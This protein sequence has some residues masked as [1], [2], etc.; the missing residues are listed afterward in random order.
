MRL[1]LTYLLP[2]HWTAVF[3]LSAAASAGE[4]GLT[5]SMLTFGLWLG[6]SGAASLILPV[7]LGL[8]ATLFFW[9][10]ISAVLEGRHFP[11]A[12]DEIVGIAFGMAVLCAT[13]I[14]VA[15]SFDQSPDAPVLA[16]VQVVALAAS[17]A[18][19]Q[20]ERRAFALASAEDEES[21]A[22]ARLMA[23]GAAHSSMLSRISGRP[24]IS[25]ERV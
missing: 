7:G 23:T 3:G 22:A 17:Y 21:R 19:I 4:T 6:D 15:G 13:V 20:A 14:T 9:S 11:G 8:V 18:A 16:A 5:P 25:G 1:V 2:L 24:T 10:F 12:F